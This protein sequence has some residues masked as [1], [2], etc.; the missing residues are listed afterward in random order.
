MAVIHPDQ[1]VDILCNPEHVRAL[2]SHSFGDA[3]G[4]REDVRELDE[5]YT[6]MRSTNTEQQEFVREVIHRQDGRGKIFEL[7]LVRD[8]Y[9]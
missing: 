3:V 1:D 2:A 8:V 9:S 5:C 4:K 6:K 7:Q